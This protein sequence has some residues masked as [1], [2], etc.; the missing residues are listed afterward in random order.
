VSKNGITSV[1]T[2]QHCE[3]DEWLIPVDPSDYDF[4]VFDGKPRASSWKPVAMRRLKDFGD[5]LP[6]RPC[7]F[8]CGGSGDSCLIMTEAAKERIDSHM[9]RYGEF[10]PLRCGD[11]HFWAFHVTHVVDALNEG[12]SNVLRATDDPDL[13]LMIKKHAFHP[14][15]IAADWMF[16]LPQSHGRGSIYVT[17]PFVS[18]IH[19]SGLT[20]LK[21]KRVWPHS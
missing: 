16:K 20:G 8:P 17:D 9:K 21:F 12:A 1:Y 4:L 19:S 13:V 18:L 7:D 2:I 10:L 3:E 5:G 15:K 14:E 11:G 6:A